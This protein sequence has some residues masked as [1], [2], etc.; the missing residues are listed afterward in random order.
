[1]TQLITEKLADL[2]EQEVLTLVRKELD[3]GTDPLEILNACRDG[4][5]LVGKRFECREYF[6]SELML[7]GEIFKHISSILK[8][9]LKTNA[10]PTK[11]KVVI[12]TVK[13]DIHNIGK[14]LVV[15][16]LQAAGYQVYDLGVDVAP[17]RFIQTLQETDARVLGLSALLTL[18][19]DAM[20]RTIASLGDAGLRGQV[21]VMIGGGP[22]NQEVCRFT[23]ADAWGHDPQA[24]VEL[25]RQWY[26]VA[27]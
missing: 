1:M 24:A 23:G 16:M 10:A 27:P 6:V 12:G 7:A 3:A 19:Y 21:K 2:E 11:G 18:G 26:G 15:A 22:I 17:A 20:Q 25:C 5:A 14:D 9:A 8:P 4:M 13:G